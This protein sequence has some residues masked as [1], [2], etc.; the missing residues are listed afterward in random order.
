M[1]ILIM[2]AHFAKSLNFFSMHGY[3]D[4]LYFSS[5]SIGF[6]VAVEICIQFLFHQL[7]FPLQLMAL[8]NLSAIF[9]L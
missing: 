8:F 3:G 9:A 4:I 1:H 5:D 7:E 6:K 2:P